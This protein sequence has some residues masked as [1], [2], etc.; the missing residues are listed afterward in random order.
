MIKFAIRTGLRGGEQFNL[1]IR[2]VRVTG[3]HPEVT[4]R[5]GSKGK[6]TK[7][8]KIRRVPLFGM[9]LEA[10]REWLERLPSYAPSNPYELMFPGPAGA[11][12]QRGK[13]LH[14]TR[15]VKGKPR[16]INPLPEYL[17]AAGIVPARRHDGRAVRWHDFRHTSGAA[18]VSGMWGRRRSLEEVK[19]LLGH[20]SVTVT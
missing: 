20:S 4:V 13:Y 5:Y 16:P 10:A 9:N 3:E 19:G 17:A 15:R 6:G 14:V 7:S 8:A 1:L 11:R 12:R 18:L 2:D